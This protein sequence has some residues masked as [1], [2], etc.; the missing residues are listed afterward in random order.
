[1]IGARACISSARY[2][3]FGNKAARSKVI[4]TKTY[5]GLTYR[6][7]RIESAQRLNGAAA[8]IANAGKT[9]IMYRSAF[10]PETLNG[11][12]MQATQMTSSAAA[13]S[14]ERIKL[15]TCPTRPMSISG[16]H[17]Q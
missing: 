5:P 7:E 14:R 2:L 17:G 3:G 8:R 1:M 15:L 13:L 4:K 6:A 16:S 12:R 9:G 11:I 10:A